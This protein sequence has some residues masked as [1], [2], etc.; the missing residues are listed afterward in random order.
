M[1]YLGGWLTAADIGPDRLYRSVSRAAGGRSWT[2]QGLAIGQQNG[3][4][5]LTG[6]A[7]TGENVDFRQATDGT[8]WMVANDY[9]SADGSQGKSFCMKAATA[10]RGPRDP[11]LARPCYHRPATRF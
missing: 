4:D 7:I 1:L 6:S 10:T 9:S 11:R 3:I 8:Y 5:A 2:W